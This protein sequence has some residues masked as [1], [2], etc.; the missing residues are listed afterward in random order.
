M[1][2]HVQ[3]D[4]GKPTALGV[5]YMDTLHNALQHFE[6][7]GFHGITGISYFDTNLNC[8]AARIRALDAAR[9]GEGK[10]FWQGAWDYSAGRCAIYRFDYTSY[11]GP[12]FMGTSE[13]AKLHV[14]CVPVEG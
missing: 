11:A 14:N 6:A 8:N 10:A 7:A 4:A 3:I 5:H 9:E 13:A 12:T 1:T 2:T